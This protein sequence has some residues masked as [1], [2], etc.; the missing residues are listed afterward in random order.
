MKYIFLGTIAPE[1]IGR[2]EKRVQSCKAKADELGMTFEAIN[3]TQGI[4]DFIDVVEASGTFI[5]LGF[6]I[7]Y[8]KQGLA[9]SPP[10]RPSTKRQ[11][12]KRC[13]LSD[14]KRE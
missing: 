13:S 12:R 4:Y 2:H 1:W 5:V 9:K 11:W 10:C 3:Y 7:W 14:L 6:S 8:A